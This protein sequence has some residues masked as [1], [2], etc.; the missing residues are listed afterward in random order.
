MSAPA[1]VTTPEILPTPAPAPAGPVK[2]ELMLPLSGANAGLG[3]ALLQAAEMALFET[4][5]ADIQLVVRD[6]GEPG[7]AAAASQELVAAGVKLI[8]GPIF[9]AD[10]AQAAPAARAAQVPMISFSTDRAVAGSGVYVMG[11][12]PQLQVDRVVRFAASH[13]AKRIAA[14]LPDSPFGRAVA[15][16]LPQSA[17]S[18]GGAVSVVEF[19]PPG[20]TD[21]S[22]YVQRLADAKDSFDAV[23][24]PEGGDAAR[25][26]VPLLAYFG[27]D[28]TRTRLL[29]TALWNDPA[30]LREPAMAGGWFAAPAGEEWAAF[31]SRYRAD[32][33]GVP[34]RIASLAYDATALAAALAR[35]PAA[36]TSAEATASGGALV[37]T[38]EAATPTGGSPFG[39]ETLTTPD[40]F[41]GIDGIFRFRTDGGVERGLAVYEIGNGSV[42]V[43]DPAPQSFVPA[44]M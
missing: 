13:G 27:V 33:G 43:I 23:L 14:L 6:T 15:S 10:V 40:G 29:G 26:A 1:P 36:K 42:T 28:R 34:P 17:L 11:I 32:Y 4:N 41:A 39:T 30:L 22:S 35:G 37:G 38:A 12:L 7:G 44:G 19:Y 24:I 3:Q 9:A 31:A 25:Q 16:Q 2:I 21:F 20:T 8:L 5:A 18:S